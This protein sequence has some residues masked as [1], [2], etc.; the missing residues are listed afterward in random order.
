MIPTDDNPP[1]HRP[2]EK[3]EDTT[4]ADMDMNFSSG[5]AAF[6]AKHF[7]KAMQLL[8]PF[9]VQG[10]A[11]A[12]YRVAIM[13]QNGLGMAR[14][15]LQA[16]R[17]MKA[18]AEQNHG[19]AQHGLGFMY[20]YGECVAMNHTMAAH[21]FQ[22]AAEQGLAGAQDNLRMMYLQGQGVPI[23]LEKGSKSPHG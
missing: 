19:L 2:T 5:I 7:S 18:A 16:Y 15:E 8:S 13:F 12:Q 22:R 14:N 6:E 4:I 21:W 17:W 3:Q 23:D 10:N 11:E 1:Q 9:T 20:L